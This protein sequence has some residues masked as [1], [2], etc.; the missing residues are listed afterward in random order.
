MKRRYVWNV[1]MY[2]PH[3]SACPVCAARKNNP[4]PGVRATA[5]RKARV[6]S[7][8]LASNREAVGHDNLGLRAVELG[9][10]VRTV[11]GGWTLRDPGPCHLHDWLRAATVRSV[12]CRCVADDCGTVIRLVYAPRDVLIAHA[13][14]YEWNDVVCQEPHSL[15]AM[16]EYVPCECD[17]ITVFTFEAHTVWFNYSLEQSLS[18]ADSSSA[19]QIP[20]FL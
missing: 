3:A 20:R 7:P 17:G 11:T 2:L 12:V 14:D 10:A 1:A 6:C 18:E 19:S 8:P 5:T 15:P 13:S 16:Y 4:P 9:G